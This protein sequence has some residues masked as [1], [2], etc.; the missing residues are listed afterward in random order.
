MRWTIVTLVAVMATTAVHAQPKAVLLI[1]GGAG[2]LT[3]DEMK[4]HGLTRE[5]FENGLADALRAGYESLQKKGATAI[6]GVESAIRSLEDNALF[7]AGKGAVLT[8]DGRAELDAS[9][10]EGR[11]DG[12]GEGK[13]DPRKRAGAVTGLHHV[14]NPIS[15]ARAVLE[16]PNSKHMF[17]A[18]EGAERYLMTDEIMKKHNLEKVSNIYFWTDRRV[19]E[20]R[21]I[22]AKQ[23]ALADSPSRRFGTVGAVAVVD[24]K[25]AAGTSTGGVTSKW[26]G[27]IGDA[28]IIGAGTYADDRACGVSCTGTG[29]VFIRH[30]V[31][32]DV[33]CRMMYKK[34]DVATASK[35]TIEQLPDEDGGVGG[36]IALDP[37]GN[38][39]AAMSPKTNGVYRGY[40][41]DK[42]N[43]YVALFAKDEW[44]K[45]EPKAK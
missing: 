18:G 37:K 34:V 10:M 26:P 2:V 8:T 9:I 45:I 39:A 13:K 14:K 24:G 33:V 29:E 16:M 3:E 17:L 42:G 25:L 11:M 12:M 23:M 27:R 43:V 40:V 20:I 30:A 6:D 22:Q 35:E 41:D 21:K 32:H 44:K 5:V 4:P 15:A 19:D 36:F 28:P 31:A 38:I 7:N 1:H